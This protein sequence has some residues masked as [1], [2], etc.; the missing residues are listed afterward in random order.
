[1]PNRELSVGLF[2][3]L[4]EITMAQAY[5]QSGTT[6]EATFSLY[7]RNYPPD[8]AYF[9]FAGLEDVLDYLEHFGFSDAD[10]D[11]LRSTGKLPES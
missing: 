9:V 10:L 6:A 3:D 4:Y 5:W 1:M 11:Y 7:F 8:R 2:T